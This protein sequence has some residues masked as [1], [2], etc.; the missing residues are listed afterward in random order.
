MTKARGWAL[1]SGAAV[2]LALLVAA[3]CGS[4]SPSAGTTTTG[5]QAVSVPHDVKVTACHLAN[6]VWLMNGTIHNSSS[7]PRAYSVV[8]DFDTQP[9]DKVV[10][11]R[12]IDTEKIT[13]GNTITF[14][15]SGAT[16]AT[17]VTCVIGKA[18]A[19]A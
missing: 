18:T 1:F 10:Q 6:N 14:G 9:H 5:A 8:V 16:G 2:S 12:R 11:S 4:S 3:G 7:T 13:P 17:G 15:A 19:T